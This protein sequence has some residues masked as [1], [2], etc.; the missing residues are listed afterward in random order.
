MTLALLLGVVFGFVGS[1]PTTGPTS[2]LVLKNAFEK[3]RGA[4]LDVA[5]GGALAEMLYAFVAFWGLTAV[6]QEFP[7]LSSIAR[8]AGAVLIIGVGIYFVVCRQATHS[9]ETQQDDQ[10]RRWIIGFA[11]AIFN[12]TLIA[13]WTSVVTAMHAASI[14]QISQAGALPFA[15][16]VGSGIM[17]WFA[18]LLTLVQ[19]FRER[20]EHGLL[21]RLVRAMGWSMIVIG[22]F[23]A[24]RVLLQLRPI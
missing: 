23:V 5:L 16:G 12:P 4:A 17:G 9:K 18:V 8:V 24:S 22:A 13:S 15:V 6:L 3:G 2:F 7:M 20:M 10:R 11:S 19:R 14:V 21:H 1:I